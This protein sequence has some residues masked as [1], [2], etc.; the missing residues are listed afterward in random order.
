MRL[1]VIDNYD[2]F[3]YNLVHITEAILQTEVTVKRNDAFELAEL[4]DYDAVVVSPGPGIPDEAGRTKQ[5]I[6]AVLG[7]KPLLGVCLGHQA[8]GEV[9]GA[10]LK[11]LD[12]VHHGVD[13]ALD[14]LEH[15]PLFSGLNDP[16]R[17]GRYHSWVIEPSSLPSN[18]LVTATDDAGEIMAVRHTEAPAWGVQFHPESVLTPQ[19]PEMLR[20]FFT[21]IRN[22]S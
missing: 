19:G 6:A 20:N 22:L 3:T 2:S 17:V 12:T 18:L 21:H 5:A 7:R 8:L 14:V 1:F 9:L 13:C 4:E 15:D 16:L 10:E 11:N